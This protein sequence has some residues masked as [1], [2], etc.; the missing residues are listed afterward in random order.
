MGLL[1][2]AGLVYLCVATHVVSGVVYD[3]TE[4][5]AIA[6]DSSEATLWINGGKFAGCRCRRS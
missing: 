2:I 5:G 3:I 4:A 6:G 1:R